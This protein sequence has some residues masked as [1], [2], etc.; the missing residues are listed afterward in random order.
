MRGPA[1][2]VVTSLALL[3]SAVTACSRPSTTA[4]PSSPM[5]SE[6]IRN[7]PAPTQSAGS[8]Q[9]I[10]GRAGALLTPGIMVGNTLYLS[11][12]L[13]SRASRDSG[14]GPETKSAIRAA[15]GILQAAG[16]DLANVVSVTAYLSNIADFQ[17]FNAAYT[18]MFT[19]DP[20]PTRTTLQV[21]ALV[22]NAKVELTM[23]A[24]RK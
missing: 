21:A 16:M 24:V 3:A 17:A 19:T 11:G 4:S 14:I 15:Q 22:G 23:V 10:N 2:R 9:P 7:A 12:Q 20:R 18:E 8:I 6:G 13:G 5:L 1:F